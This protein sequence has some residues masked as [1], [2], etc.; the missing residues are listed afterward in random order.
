M[1]LIMT[2]TRL[3]ARLA[4]AGASLKNDPTLTP[5]AAWQGM[6]HTSPWHAPGQRGAL[7]CS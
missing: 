6:R 4:S 2:L 1:L 7:G 3:H 5:C